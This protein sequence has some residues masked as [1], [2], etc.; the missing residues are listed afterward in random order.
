[1]KQSDSCPNTAGE[2]AA[3][4]QSIDVKTTI[5]VVILISLLAL[6]TN[7]GVYR[8][9]SHRPLTDMLRYSGYIAVGVCLLV[10]ADY[11]SYCVFS[12]KEDGY[13]RPTFD[14]VSTVAIVRIS[15]SHAVAAAMTGFIFYSIAVFFLDLFIWVR[16]QPNQVEAS[17]TAAGAIIIG[18]PLF[19][20]RKKYR[21]VYGVAEVLVGMAVGALR[22]SEGFGKISLVNLTFAILTAGAYL[23]VRGLDN[24]ET[25]FKAA[26][27]DPVAAKIMDWWNIAFKRSG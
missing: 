5:S 12:W 9:L 22:M 26:D 7:Y 11:V 20:V 16:A 24:I 18:V 14:E 19:F 8:S 15:L 3:G 2:N 4:R 21:M 13:K 23:V 10:L 1:M 25:G 27:R 6:G 17:G